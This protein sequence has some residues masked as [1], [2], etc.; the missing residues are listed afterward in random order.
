VRP[1]G[2]A[3][4]VATALSVAG[5][6]LVGAPRFARGDVVVTKDGKTLE[7]KV[8]EQN[9]NRVVVETTF[10]GTKAVARADVKSVDVKTPPLRVQ[11]TFRMDQAKDDVA[12]LT[13]LAGWAKGKGFKD[14]VADVWKRVLVLDAANVRAHKAL[15]HVKVG[16]AWMTPEEKAAAEK[17]AFEEGQKAKG[18]VLHDGK[19]V[20]KEEKEALD[21]GLLK[22]GDAWV[23][24]EEYHR[25]RGEKLVDGKWV[26]VGE[27]KGKERVGRLSKAV[28]GEFAYL[29]GPHIDLF[30]ELK[31]EEGQ[32]V[33]AAA[34]KAWEAFASIVKVGET[35]GLLDLRVEVVCAHKAPTLSRYTQF[36]AEEN[37]IS[38]IRGQENWAQST[39]GQRFAWWPD[40]PMVCGYL[41]PNTPKALTSG[42]THH[43]VF[44][45]LTRYRFNYRF[46]NKWL[47]EG[48]AYAIEMR[49]LGE[50]QTYTVDVQ[51]AL[52][53]IDPV[54][55]QDSSKWQTSLRTLV[56]ASQ[57]TPASRVTAKGA[58]FSM[59]DLLKAWSL[60]ECLLKIDPDRFKQFID[61]TKSREFKDEP[62]E[63]SLHEA[64]GFDFRALE[65]RWRAW[66][67]AGF[68]TP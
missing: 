2:G 16:T 23:T 62:D 12:A 58:Q 65:T 34:E 15:G 17:A 30:H 63:K 54:L 19:W 8:V 24:E 43:L 53:G 4:R 64:F 3:V 7:G 33:L 14:E 28:D 44:A 59:P 29:W 60:V 66:V 1:R 32:M 31:P 55:L 20:T 40:P 52:G 18:L 57:D 37:G 35:D 13:E 25:R 42:I 39:R 50:S 22:D 9:E 51:G 38:K 36:F 21:K 11:L 61:T 68:G 6:L 67:G 49:T 41:F 27:E 26:R 47:Q 10:D 45:W 5:L 48:L 56:A 46:S